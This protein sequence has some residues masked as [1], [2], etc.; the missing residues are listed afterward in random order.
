MGSNR[1]GKLGISN[2]SIKQMGTPTLVESLLKT[3][4]RRVY[5]GSNHL[6]ALAGKDD[7]NRSFSLPKK[8][9]EKI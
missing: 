9:K 7:P 3:P 2:K 8:E 6:F 1:D 5:S 4:L